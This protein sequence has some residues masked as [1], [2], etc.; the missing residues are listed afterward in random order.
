MEEYYPYIY[1]KRHYRRRCDVTGVLRVGAG[2][3][4]VAGLG[5]CSFFMA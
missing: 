4:G 5:L 3:S 1:R 2:V